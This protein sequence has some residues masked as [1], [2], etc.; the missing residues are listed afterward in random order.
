MLLRRS[1]DIINY[2]VI[3]QLDNTAYASGLGLG[4]MT[5]NMVAICLGSGLSGGLETLC[6]QAFG[7]NNNHQAGQYYT[8]AQVI[9]T[10]LFIPQAIL[11]YFATPL[12]MATGQPEQSSIVAGE[13][14]KICL[15]GIWAYWQTEL[16]RR[17]LGTQGIFHLV[18]NFQILNWFLHVIWVFLFVYG[19][20]LSYKGV[21]YASLVTFML[22][23]F[24]PMLYITYNKSCI[25]DNCWLPI[26]K[27]S[28][29]N[30]GEYLKYGLPSM[31]MLLFECWAFEL[32]IFTV[33][34]LG[35]KE[36]AVFVICFNIVMYAYMIPLGFQ[37]A[38]NSWVGNSLG[39]SKP[40]TAKI[41][42]NVWIVSAILLSIF[43]GGWQFLFRHQLANIFVDTEMKELFTKTLS[44]MLLLCFGQYLQTTCQGM[45]KAMGY[46]KYG[47]VICL[48]GYWGI[49]IPFTY[50][51]TFTFDLKMTGVLLGA[52]VGLIFIG[53]GY[54]TLV[55]KTDFQK[56]SDEIIGRLQ[57]ER[58]GK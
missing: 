29:W 16:L 53:L 1:P 51:F 5:I 46:Q 44:L 39:A 40:K 52:P 56:L 21:F 37:F 13:Y 11:L 18:M 23:Y 54:I 34:I 22:N 47:T 9:L 7:S 4:M 38:I 43:L 36:L 48:F 28:F 55:C 31:I 25:R 17:F 6:S 42:V 32:L 41:Y 26:S 2:A 12:L 24:L 14:I 8:R 10:F 19:L 3:S 57:E 58:K 50:L 49:C 15:P 20:D 35:E 27:Q 30:L 33:G 45:I